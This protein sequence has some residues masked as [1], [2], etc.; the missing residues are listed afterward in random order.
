MSQLEAQLRRHGFV[1]EKHRAALFQP[2]INRR[3][4]LKLG[5]MLE[6]TGQSLSNGMAGGVILVEASKESPVRPK[7]LTIR[8]RKPMRILEGLAQP[9]VKPARGQGCIRQ[10]TDDL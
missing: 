2:P 3:F 6:Q 4:W 7:G 5:P 10:V 8:D 9:D 1:P